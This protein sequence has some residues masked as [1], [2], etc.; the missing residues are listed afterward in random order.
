M[1]VTRHQSMRLRYGVA[2]SSEEQQLGEREQRADDDATGS[3][4]RKP[5]G[6]DDAFQL[7]EQLF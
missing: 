7:L 5:S 1:F 4:S 6:N 2:G 3:S